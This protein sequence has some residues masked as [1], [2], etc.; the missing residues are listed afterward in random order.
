VRH[1]ASAAVSWDV[2]G[3][4]RLLSG[5][6][7]DAIVYAR[8]S[9]PVNVTGTRSTSFGFVAVRPDRIPDAR[10][11]LDDPDAPGGR[12]INASAFRFASEE[13]QGTLG[14][15]T[16]RGFPMWQVDLALRREVRLAQRMRLLIRAEL[17]NALNHSNFGRP[18]GNLGTVAANATLTP[19]PTFGVATASLRNSLPGLSSLYQVGGSRSAQLSLRLEF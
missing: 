9:L 1:A 15:N 4:S 14:R 16:L 18:N 17:F 12:R 10:L 13:R 6:G 5:W 3:S 8:S 11:Y 2:P 19:N 7:A